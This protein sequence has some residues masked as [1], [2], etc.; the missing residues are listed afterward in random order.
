[1]RITDLKGKPLA[2]FVEA[3]PKAWFTLGAKLTESI[4][5]WVRDRKYFARSSSYTPSY[6]KRKA[7]R[8]A[9]PKGVPQAST[10]QQV[11]LTLTGK[12]LADIKVKGEPHQAVLTWLGF[13]AEKLQWQA[14]QGRDI[15]GDGE[16]IEPV[17][18]ELDKE[19]DKIYEK[20][21]RSMAG[22]LTL[23]V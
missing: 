20:R 2:T 3:D 21:V 14:D 18:R 5:A 11:D 9:A 12:M 17:D 16:L 13:N 1:M 22:S 6:A 7:N 19:L 23:R 8:K 15:I 4:R 10:S